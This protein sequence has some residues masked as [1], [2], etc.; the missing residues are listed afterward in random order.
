MPPK[1]AGF[2]CQAPAEPRVPL[3]APGVPPDQMW[4]GMRRPLI[5]LMTMGRPHWHLKDVQ[6]IG[7]SL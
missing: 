5:V 1:G 2:C 7:G 3:S 4:I 6:T